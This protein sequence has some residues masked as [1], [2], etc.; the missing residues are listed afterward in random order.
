MYVAGAFALF[1][2]PAKD[3]FIDFPAGNNVTL[4]SLAT[5][6]FSERKRL[7]VQPKPFV[8][9]IEELLLKGKS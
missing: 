9:G 1:S 4:Q 3:P 6:L 8:G 5:N 7:L 2:L